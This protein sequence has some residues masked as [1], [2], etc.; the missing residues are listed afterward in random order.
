LEVYTLPY[1]HKFSNL[2]YSFHNDPSNHSFPKKQMFS[3]RIY[4]YFTNT[5]IIQKYSFLFLIFQILNLQL[6]TFLEVK[7]YGFKFELHPFRSPLLRIS[8]LISFLPLN[9]MLK[10]SGFS[11]ISQ[12]KINGTEKHLLNNIIPK[13]QAILIKY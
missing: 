4:W 3:K 1:S 9:N 12:A 2:C 7:K 11:N 10:F 5:I 13:L 8:L 6:H